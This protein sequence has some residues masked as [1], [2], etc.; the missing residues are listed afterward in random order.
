MPCKSFTVNWLCL[1]NPACQT[2]NSILFVCSKATLKKFGTA[3][4]DAVVQRLAEADDKKLTKDELKEKFEFIKECKVAI[5]TS[6]EL[7]DTLHR[8]S[9]NILIGTSCYRARLPVH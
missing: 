1:S 2:N 7:K 3:N 9:R 6:F 8:I 5:N 4:C